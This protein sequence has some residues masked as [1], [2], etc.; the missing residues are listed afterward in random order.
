HH[1]GGGVGAFGD[2]ARRHVVGARG[3]KA[4]GDA[5][6]DGQV[7]GAVPDQIGTRADVAFKIVRVVEADTQRGGHAGQQAPLVLDEKRLVFLFDHVDDAAADLLQVPGVHFV[8]GEL[9]ADGGVVAAGHLPR[10]HQFGVQGPVVGFDIA[11][12]GVFLLEIHIAGAEIPAAD[13]RLGPGFPFGF[14]VPVGARCAAGDP[15]V[16]LEI[17]FA[18][19]QRDVLVVGRLVPQAA[20]EV[21]VDALRLAAG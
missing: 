21:A 17:F 6:L 16:H 13:V 19:F 4:G 2:Q 7:V 18:A 11:L 10:R 9:G 12:G 5:A 1:A 3:Q 15:G 8:V 14:L 20:G